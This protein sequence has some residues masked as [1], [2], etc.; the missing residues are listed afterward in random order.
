MIKT[1]F[2]MNDEIFITRRFEGGFTQR[3][4]PLTEARMKRLCIDPVY[5]MF[6]INNRIYGMLSN[7]ERYMR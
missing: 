2:V 1:V 4:Y 3:K 7:D 6:V 5:K